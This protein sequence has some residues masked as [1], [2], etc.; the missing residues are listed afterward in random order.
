MPFREKLINPYVIGQTGRYSSWDLAVRTDWA[1]CTDL[2]GYG[3]WWVSGGHPDGTPAVGVPLLHVRVPLAGA[4]LVPGMCTAV[5]HV[6][7]AHS[8]VGTDRQ[9]MD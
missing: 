5:R 9:G 7:Q 3:K 8:E 4:C 1:G 6:K 2:V